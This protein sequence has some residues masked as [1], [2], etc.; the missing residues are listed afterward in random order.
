MI[1]IQESVEFS[2]TAWKVFA[3]CPGFVRPNP[4]RKSEE[5]RSG[6][7]KAGDLEVSGERVLSILCE[8]RD[9]DAGKFGHRDGIYPW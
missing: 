8:E 6:W 9:V 3:M 1:T 5:E 4:R 7:G 2:E